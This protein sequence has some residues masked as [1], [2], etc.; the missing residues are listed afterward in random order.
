MK[1]AVVQQA[2]IGQGKNLHSNS[3]CDKLPNSTVI[4]DVRALRIRRRSIPGE[5]D[6]QG[7]NGFPDVLDLAIAHKRVK[8]VLLRCMARQ[9]ES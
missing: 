3:C 4:G 6:A 5:S 9:I 1:G 2:V 7:L 8:H